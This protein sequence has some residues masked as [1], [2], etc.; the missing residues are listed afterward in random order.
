MK[1]L[2]EIYSWEVKLADKL[3]NLASIPL[4]GRCPSY[5]LLPFQGAD[6][7]FFGGGATQGVA[8]GYGLLPIWGDIPR[9][10]LDILAL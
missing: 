9:W 1:L 10:G 4:S 3:W 7:Y 6:V 2:V 5:I 8:L